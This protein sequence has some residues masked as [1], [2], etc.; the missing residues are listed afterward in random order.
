MIPPPSVRRSHLPRLPP[1]YYLGRT[2]V[3]WTMTIQGRNTGW[4]IPAFHTRFRFIL[5]HVLARYQLACPVYCLMPDHLHMIWTGL[6]DASDQRRARVFFRQHL[7]RELS[8]WRLQSQAFDH[9]LR[10]QERVSDALAATAKY[11]LENPVRAGLCAAW[12]EYP[13]SNALIAGYPTLDIRQ[14]NFWDIFF[15]VISGCP[16]AD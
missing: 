12:Q 8:P 4:L 16:P 14:E 7:N 2:L 13:Y 9:V 11:I 10:T 15:R 1:E 6:V 3:H 5:L